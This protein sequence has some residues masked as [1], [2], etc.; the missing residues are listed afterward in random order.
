MGLQAEYN[1]LSTMICFKKVQNKNIHQVWHRCEDIYIVTKTELPT[2]LLMQN[3]FS[4][5]QFN[6]TSFG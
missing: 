4:I 3:Y 6:M 1:P 2:E 5:S